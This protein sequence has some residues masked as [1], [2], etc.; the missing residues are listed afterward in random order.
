MVYTERDLLAVIELQEERSSFT[1]EELF[2]AL[3]EHPSLAVYVELRGSLYGIIT[4]GRIERA[5]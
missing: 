2:R 5:Y 1:Y 4:L 3:T